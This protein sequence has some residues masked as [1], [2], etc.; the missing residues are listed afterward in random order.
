MKFALICTTVFVCIAT[1][2][3]AFSGPVPAAIPS[4][5]FMFGLSNNPESIDWM[6]SSGVPWEFRYQYLTRG[7]QNWGSDFAYKYMTAS[8]TNGYFPV[9]TYYVIFGFGGEGIDNE[10]AT[11]NDAAEMNEYFNDFR[12]LMDQ[13]ARY[14]GPVIVHLEPDMYGYMVQK[15]GSSMDART[16]SAAVS[17]SGQADA[18]ASGAPDNFAGF[19]QVLEYMRDT[20]A[21][22]VLLA[23]MMNHWGTRDPQ[24]AADFM[25]SL[26]VEWDLLFSEWSDRDAEYKNNWFDQDDFENVLDYDDVLSENTNLRIMLWQIPCGNMYIDPSNS[27]ERYKDNRSEYIF[28]H[29][30][31]MAG[32]GIIGVLF[33]R[34]RD[35]QTTYGDAGDPEQGYIKC[36]AGEYYSGT[37][38]TCSPG[39][40][41]LGPVPLP[42]A[43]GTVAEIAATAV[44]RA[45]RHNASG[46]YSLL[47]RRINPG[48]IHNRMVG[49]R[50]KVVSGRPVVHRIGIAGGE[51]MK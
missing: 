4:H 18:I 28:N 35:D 33:G 8:R 22:K 40:S 48:S 38:G 17:A 34:G 41:T 13:C 36:W 16:V 39:S 44:N 2:A 29:V 23:P 9:F 49:Y 27:P 37:K 19:N 50:I 32:H 42:G 45:E 47:G 24:K 21:P 12:E 11:L 10:Y 7:W 25:N 15:S 5:N 51:R 26:G 6:T 14:D 43:G 20:Y 3:Y 1:Q 46:W 31:H 30:A